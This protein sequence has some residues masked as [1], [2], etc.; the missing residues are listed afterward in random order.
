M[1][2]PRE[3]VSAVALQGTLALVVAGLLSLQLLPVSVI[4]IFIFFPHNPWHSKL[5]PVIVPMYQIVSSFFEAARGLLIALMM[6]A[7]RTFETSVNFYETTRRNIPEG[8]RLHT[9]RREN[10][11]SDRLIFKFR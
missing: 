7:V 5:Q 6:E 9:R 10:L 2:T 1:A 3:R 8:C 4:I 11:K